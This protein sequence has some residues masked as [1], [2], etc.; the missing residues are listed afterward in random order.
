MDAITEQEQTVRK[1][2]RDFS[3]KDF[4]THVG[5]FNI[6]STI[7]V[8]ENPSSGTFLGIRMP[9]QTRAML[10]IH[11]ATDIARDKLNM[12]ASIIKS[13]SQRTDHV[14][15]FLGNP[16]VELVKDGT[17]KE[18]QSVIVE[19]VE[20]RNL[21]DVIQKNGSINTPTMLSLLGTVAESLDALHEE[22]YVHLDL[23][24]KNIIWRDGTTDGVLLDFDNVKKIGERIGTRPE[25]TTGFLGPEHIRQDTEVAASLDIWQ[26]AAVAYNAMTGHTLMNPRQ[27][28]FQLHHDMSEYNEYLTKQIAEIPESL[29]TVF[30]KALAFEPEQ[31][32]TTATEFVDSLR[33]AYQGKDTFLYR[34]RH[35]KEKYEG[36]HRINY[37]TDVAEQQSDKPAILSNN[38]AEQVKENP[39]ERE[40]TVEYLDSDI[41]GINMHGP[42]FYDE[43]DS[44]KKFNI[45]DPMLCLITA[46]EV[47]IATK[48]GVFIQ[49]ER[50]GETVTPVLKLVLMHTPKEGVEQRVDLDTGKALRQG[51]N[52]SLW[53][54]G[55]YADTSLALDEEGILH[56]KSVGNMSYKIT[57]NRDSVIVAT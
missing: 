6:D 26:L 7:P 35:K 43:E 15:H 33:N 36:R 37:H 31:R 19:Y 55:I 18:Y 16:V 47:G 20:G 17:K 46:N 56:F 49:Q 54:S 2:P 22:G 42:T 4:T 40:T 48:W 25:G 29:H 52:I 24:P 11:S 32:Y 44:R 41:E 28:Q 38:E 51:E 3:P 34:G 1:I 50:K 21:R 14:P 57:A 39:Q 12:E 10:K 23:A 9:D 5:P 13:L 30:L 8:P 45:S 53:D 27:Y